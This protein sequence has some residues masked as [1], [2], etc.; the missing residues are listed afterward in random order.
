MNNNNSRR[1]VIK[2]SGFG[3]LELQNGKSAGVAWEMD[4]LPSGTIVNGYLC[5]GDRKFIRAAAR[6]KRAK[7]II[8]PI[9]A[10]TVAIN[11]SHAGRLSFTG[12]LASG[13]I[14]IP[15]L[16]KT[17][18]IAGFRLVDHE[19]KDFAIDFVDAEGEKR[20]VVVPTEVLDEY[21]PILRAVVTEVVGPRSPVPIRMPAEIR[22][23]IG[24]D[25]RLVYVHFDHDRLYALS[26]DDARQLAAKLVED[27]TEVEIYSTRFH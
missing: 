1:R 18:A 4:L 27:A 23:R 6:A 7:L 10:V 19:G 25:Q 5:G 16:I 13:G 3:H 21:L 20:C 2:S 9:I 11:G 14:R 12:S 15:G 24:D 26:P 17:Q 22:T 8:P